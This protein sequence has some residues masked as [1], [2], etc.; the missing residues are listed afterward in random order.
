MKQ[1]HRG[2]NICKIRV[3]IRF[4]QSFAKN[5]CFLKIFANICSKGTTPSF[6]QPQLKL[7]PELKPWTRNGLATP[8]CTLSQC[9]TQEALWL[10]TDIMS[11]ESFSHYCHNPSQSLKFPGFQTVQPVTSLFNI[12]WR[13]LFVQGSR[14]RFFTCCRYLF[15]QCGNPYWSCASKAALWNFNTYK[16]PPDTKVN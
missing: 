13:Q 8:K 2:L 15:F 14:M 16:S 10:W 4:C 1:L 5:V 11:L 7:K 9:S 3:C 6:P 12:F